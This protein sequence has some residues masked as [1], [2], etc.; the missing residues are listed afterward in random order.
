[1]GKKVLIITDNTGGKFVGRFSNGEKLH[2]LTLGPP[3]NQIRNTSV[4]M[5][6]HLIRVNIE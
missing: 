2:I 5:K 1:M 4:F 6:S 3:S